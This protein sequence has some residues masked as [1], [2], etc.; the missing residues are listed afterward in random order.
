MRKT[1]L[2]PII[3]LLTAVLFNATVRGAVNSSY[4]A[5][6]DGG[7]NPAPT[8]ADPNN[9]PTD[10]NSNNWNWPA[11]WNSLNSSSSYE[12]GFGKR[13]ITAD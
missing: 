1:E 5:I 10:P 12:V 6:P 4:V 13:R 9:A 8:P 2:L 3:I 11:P 7:F